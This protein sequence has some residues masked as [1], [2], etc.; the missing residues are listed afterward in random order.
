MKALR[1]FFTRLFYRHAPEYYSVVA[2]SGG[3]RIKAVCWRCGKSEVSSGVLCV[4]G[5]PSW[6]GRP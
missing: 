5:G 4:W 2:A 1:A 6:S 3:I